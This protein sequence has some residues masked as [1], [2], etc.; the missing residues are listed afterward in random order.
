MNLLTT[1]Y[2][3]WSHFLEVVQICNSFAIILALWDF[4]NLTASTRLT[5]FRFA[6][7]NFFVNVSCAGSD[8]LKCDDYHRPFFPTLGMIFPKLTILWFT[9]FCDHKTGMFFSWVKKVALQRCTDGIWY[10]AIESFVPKSKVVD[11]YTPPCFLRIWFKH[12]LS[13]VALTDGVN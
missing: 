9:G 2:L 11:F 7:S 13:K 1:I 8:L 3:I 6:F 12:K 10:S 5:K 4:N